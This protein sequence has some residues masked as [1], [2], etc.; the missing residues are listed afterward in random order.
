MGGE[1]IKRKANKIYH[2]ENKRLKPRDTMTFNSTNLENITTPHANPL[3]ISTTINGY[4]VKRVLVNTRE[5]VVI[6]YLDALKNMFLNE[7]YLK[8]SSNLIKEFVQ[9]KFR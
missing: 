9:T 5:S 1:V 3:V 8:T 2:K 6:L 4:K 7:K